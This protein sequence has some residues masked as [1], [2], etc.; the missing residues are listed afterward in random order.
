MATLIW[1]K[2]GDEIPLV[3]IHPE[4]YSYFVQQLDSLNVNRYVSNKQLDTEQTGKD[5]SDRLDQISHILKEKFNIT[6]LVVDNPNFHDQALLN[7]LHT[8]WVKLHQ[9]YPNIAMLCEKIEEGAA[10]H[11]YQINKLVHELEETFNKILLIND[12]ISIPNDFNHDISMFG[13]T[14]LMINYNNLGRTS[15][16]KWLNFDTVVHDTD[17]NNY[18]E[19]YTELTM[20]LARPRTQT[21]PVEYV[22][23][24][25]ENNV[26]AIGETIGLANFDKLEENLL[27]YRELVY[28][29][30]QSL[31]NFI[32]LKE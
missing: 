30:T 25:R 22:E 9:R 10:Y 29:N 15:F 16:N 12:V 2:S 1:S 24:A 23:W 6:D 13:I 32:I 11:I 27:S 3:P 20:T 7:R 31:E 19:L 17:T 21:P 5:L 28:R 18:K 8:A 14:N 26:L 4:V